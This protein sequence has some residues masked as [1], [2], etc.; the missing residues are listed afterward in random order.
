M[1]LI[2]YKEELKYQKNREDLF[3]LLSKFDKNQYLILTL[4]SIIS[5]NNI[6]DLLNLSE[7]S[8][9]RNF[10]ITHLFFYPR[11]IK[12]INQMKIFQ[13]IADYPCKK[14]IYIDD[15][16]DQNI[17]LN[18]INKFDNKLITYPYLVDK[19]LPQ[20]NNNIIKF[21]HYINDQF[22]KSP[23]NV[24]NIQISILGHYLKKTYITRRYIIIRNYLINAK[25]KNC[26]I[27]SFKDEVDN[28]TYYEILRNSY[29]SIA[30]SCDRKTLYYPYIVSKYFE[31][32]GCGALLIAHVLPEMEEELSRL[33]FVDNLNYIAFKNVDELIEKCNYIFDEKNKNEIETIRINGYNLIK[34]NHLISHRIKELIKIFNN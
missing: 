20:I 21:P 16:H 27:T 9:L 17:N 26:S 29:A 3:L 5:E 30:T 4:D 12:I 11:Q 7:I 18:I 28:L 22:C 8:Q 6:D 19:F 23:E 1:I 14:T 10:N 13:L 15:L 25:L 33:G 31:I 34:N 32:P 2:I 24:R